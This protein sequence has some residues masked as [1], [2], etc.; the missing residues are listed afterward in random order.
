MQRFV[1]PLLARTPEHPAPGLNRMLAA[2]PFLPVRPSLGTN[3]G[4]ATLY[5]E[6]LRRFQ[7]A[8]ISPAWRIALPTLRT[9]FSRYRML[10]ELGIGIAGHEALR[11][12]ALRPASETSADAPASVPSALTMD[13]LRDPDQESEADLGAMFAAPF[14]PRPFVPV[15]QELRDRV[16]RQHAWTGTLTSGAPPALAI[17]QAVGRA[18]WGIDA[19][20]A[21]ASDEG[22]PFAPSFTALPGVF[23]LAASI[24]RRAIP[25]T[26]AP[27]VETRMLAL[28]HIARSVGAP[29]EAGTRSTL[30]GAL[31]ARV[32]NV[33]IHTDRPAARAAEM[34]SARAFTIDDHVFFARGAYQPAQPAG[35]ALLGHELVHVLQQRAT[36]EEAGRSDRAGATGGPAVPIPIGATFAGGIGGI[37]G[38]ATARRWI[39]SLALG[40]ASTMIG[41]ARMAIGGTAGGAPA[42]GRPATAPASGVAGAGIDRAAIGMSQAAARP[43]PLLLPW[44]GAP[45]AAAPTATYRGEPFQGAESWPFSGGTLLRSFEPS[46]AALAESGP[47][48]SLQRGP[49]VED[50]GAAMLQ[51]RTAGAPSGEPA[52]YPSG[53]SP[54]GWPHGATAATATATWAAALLDPP[55]PRGGA[56]TAPAPEPGRIL[57]RF[58]APQG[59]GATREMVG[60]LGLRAAVAGLTQ[61]AQAV[62]ASHATQAIQATQVARGESAAPITAERARAGLTLPTAAWIAGISG[63]SPPPLAR[64]A[65]AMATA[66]A[67][68]IQRDATIDA[69]RTGGMG[70]IPQGAVLPMQR[71]WPLIDTGAAARLQRRMDA[72][73][74]TGQSAGAPLAAST[75]AIMER[76]LGAP[77]GDVRVHTD[78]P[79]ARAAGA[80]G[81]QAFALGRSVFFAPTAFQ[82][83][84]PAGMALLGHELTHVLQ[85]QNMPLRK[86]APGESSPFDEPEPA[87]LEA[88]ALQTEAMLLRRFSEPATLAGGRGIA[89]I[90]AG[91][92]PG[93]AAGGAGQSAALEGAGPTTSSAGMLAGSGRILRFAG[94][95]AAPLPV[96]MI[97]RIDAPA[98]RPIS[99][100]DAPPYP[101]MTVPAGGGGWTGGLTIGRSPL[102]VFA[103]ATFSGTAGGGGIA[104]AGPSAASAAAAS[105]D[106]APNDQPAD[107]SQAPWSAALAAAPIGA[108]GGG[109]G[110]GA[111]AATQAFSSSLARRAAA[112]EGAA[113]G[114]PGV[115]GG[116]IA[117]MTMT[118]LPN[119][120]I[121]PTVSV[122]DDGD[123]QGS[124]DFSEPVGALTVGP[125]VAAAAVQ[126][127][128][129]GAMR[130][131]PEATPDAGAQ[132]ANS[133]ADG[134]SAGGHGASKSGSDNVDEIVERVVA[135][136]KRQ[137][138]LDHERSGGVISQIMH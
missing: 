28:Q 97:H 130:G 15:G 42:L 110:G 108:G 37:G 58:V 44:R 8:A 112:P 100:L 81:A 2:R 11:R 69:A 72:M 29:I 56:D 138:E 106:G 23:R 20:E 129:L 94:D 136:I 105:G 60:A 12:A 89:A 64:A 121:A 1:T 123:G 50:A 24:Q 39:G 76:M 3:A 30:E 80:L 137:L 16:G 55:E 48:Q 93:A 9:H 91:W 103:G 53:P 96:G 127:R 75:R 119:A 101:S 63:G 82:P 25:G 41:T 70:P 102:P 38:D 74:H 13:W 35:L 90:D 33:Q 122:A 54:A 14:A 10:A 86:A 22:A 57:M 87:A 46:N 133:A 98:I 92:T 83:S 49:L 5:D 107:R 132:S 21:L 99:R 51:A 19:V 47:P 59:V 45:G 125:G 71:A 40:D 88:Q 124:G 115:L 128:D 120:A 109:W 4:T 118:Q 32:G 79:A 135:Q 52:A 113:P 31:G 61:A 7:P 84:T 68:A 85:R 114:A 17:A 65:T 6:V 62:H 134:A 111:L 26:D 27:A 126:R 34:L 18:S 73:E 36:G 116:R 78:A 77:L 117:R 131:A 43:L 67:R 95:R 66:A 104:G